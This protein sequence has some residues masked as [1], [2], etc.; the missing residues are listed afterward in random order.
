MVYLSVALAKFT[1][2]DLY[3]RPFCLFVYNHGI[4]ELITHYRI[5]FTVMN[6]TIFTIVIVLFYCNY[7]SALVGPG[8]LMVGHRH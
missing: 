7:C 4:N 3:S 5:V 2:R 6:I 8:K 1:K